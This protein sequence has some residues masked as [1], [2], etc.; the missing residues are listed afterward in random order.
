MIAII[1]TLA[2]RRG[3]AWGESFVWF[4]IGCGFHTLLD[5]FTHVNDGPVLLYPF[6]WRY[7][8]RAPV[9]YWDPRHGGRTFAMFE[10]AL[11][12]GLVIYLINA[13]YQAKSTKT[14]TTSS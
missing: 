5:I 11:D 1:G 2:M 9:S 6:N 8:Y 12:I 10:L 7:R 4:A 3:K 13:W 14:S